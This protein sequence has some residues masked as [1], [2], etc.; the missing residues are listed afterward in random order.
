MKLTKYAHACLALE[1]QGK[2]LV[3][4]PGNLTPEFGALD[5]IVAV[6]V[7]HIHGDHF[8]PKHLD[9][10]V[11]ANPD[12]QIFTT[13]EI[14]KAWGHAH[15]TA[16][17]ASQTQQVGPF[18][19]EFFG[20][21]HALIHS[22]KPIAQNIGVMVNDTLFYT[23][24]A[25]TLPERPVPVLALT[26]NAPWLKVS[27]SIEYLKTVQPSN[28]FFRTHDELLSANGKMVYDVWF[29]TAAEAYKLTFKPL[30][31]GQSVEI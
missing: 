26:A 17:K 28:F 16:A 22:L 24:D 12:V 18:K 31:A 8:E 7:T 3:I 29:N 14:V 27:D 15:V 4:D 5:N 19:L 6:V 2:K 20:E 13:P 11:A 21:K 30:E 1:E 23:G 10:I 9:A 25:L